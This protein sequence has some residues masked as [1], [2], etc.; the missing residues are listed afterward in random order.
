VDTRATLGSLLV[1]AWLSSACNAA[2]TDPKGDPDPAQPPAAADFAWD[3]VAT[4]AHQDTPS[5]LRFPVPATGYRVTATHF[6]PATPPEK[7]KHELRIDQDRH[8]VVRIEVWNDSEALGLTAWFDKYLRF[9]VTPDAVVEASRAGRG[10]ANAIVVRHPRSEQALAR[11]SVVFAADGRILRVTSID[12]A[13][14]RAR[15]VFEH[16]LAGLEA[17]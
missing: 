9:M 1:A 4:R 11:R 8:E 6:D 13:D 16:V 5:S 3:G 2:S 10:N 15:A 14:S 7:M 17:D 12:D